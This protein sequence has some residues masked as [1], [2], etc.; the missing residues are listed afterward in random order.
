MQ[1]AYNVA[2]TSSFDVAK[3]IN[4]LLQNVA[5]DNEYDY[6]VS[7]AHLQLVARDGAHT[8]GHIDGI[9]VLDICKRERASDVR[10]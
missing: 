3:D 5:R 10:V 4:T 9:V 6:D 1:K 8:F 2:G 7:I